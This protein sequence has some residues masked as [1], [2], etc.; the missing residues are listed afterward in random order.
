[1]NI[2]FTI[3]QL[4]YDFIARVFPGFLFL[5]ALRV[6]L[7]GTGIDPGLIIS[8]QSVTSVGNVLE[9][10][11]FLV[12]CYFAGWILRS[13][14]WPNLQPDESTDFRTMYQRLRLQHPEAGFRVVKLRAEARL[15][16][17]SRMGML[18]VGGLVLVAWIFRSTNLVAGDS[19]PH[20]VWA[21]RI[22]LPVLIGL[23]FLSRERAAWKTYRG[24]V[25]KIHSLIFDDG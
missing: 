11:G 1:M 10:L 3:P 25:K 7:A 2:S 18:I 12:L 8:I 15:L 13:L 14:R 9:G 23:V 6:C 20:S 16:E 21:L 19:I 4:F 22:V 5:F 17:A 24:N